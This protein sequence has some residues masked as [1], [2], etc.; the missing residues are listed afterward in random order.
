MKTS[1]SEQPAQTDAATMFL[2]RC[3]KTAIPA[4][5]IKTT[6]K[7]VNHK[8]KGATFAHLQ[9]FK[10]HPS[11]IEQD[12]Q[13]FGETHTAC[14]RKCHQ[15]LNKRVVSF[16]R[17][18]F[19]L[20]PSFKHQ[21]EWLQNE[22]IRRKIQG[23]HNH[24]Y[25][26]VIGEG[27]I[28][29]CREAFL[30]AFGITE[31]FYKRNCAAFNAPQ[32][33][34][35]KEV[36]RTASCD[37]ELCF[38]EWVKKEAQQIGDKLPHGDFLLSKANAEIRLPYPN[39]QV[40]YDRYR[41]FMVHGVGE[42]IGQIISYQDAVVL[43]KHHP[44]LQAI[45]L[46]KHKK[47]FSKCNT[48][49]RYGMK[50]KK[51]LTVLQKEHLDNDFY[52]HI[53]E[54]KKERAQYAKDKIKGIKESEN[55]NGKRLVVIMDAIDKWKTTFPFFINLPK[56]LGD[57]VY[58]FRTKMTACMAHG[59]GVFCF[60]ASEQVTQDTN[61]SITCLL[62]CLKHIQKQIFRKCKGTL[63]KMLC[64]QL[65]NASE[66]KS[67]HFLAFMAYLVEI[68]AFDVIKLSYLI[69]AHTHE[70]VDQWFSVWSRFLKYVLMQVL[71]IAAFVEGLMSAFKSEASKPKCVEQI[72]YC[73]DTSVLVEC[74]DKHL[75]RFDLDEKTNDKV[76]HFIFRR[77]SEG[78]SV[79]QYKM[80]RYSNAVYPR[81]YNVGDTHV[82]ETL[83]S[84]QVIGAKAEKN[85][86]TKEKYWVYTVKYKTNDV[87][88]HNEE[89]TLPAKECGIIM[90]PNIKPCELPLPSSFQLAP[91]HPEFQQ[92]LLDQ[93]KG[94]TSI[95]QV[96]QIEDT[97]QLE[98]QWWNDFFDS[99]PIDVHSF[100]DIQAFWIPPANTHDIHS[101][102]VHSETVLQI[103]DGCRDV[104]IVQHAQ[105]TSSK[106]RRAIQTFECEVVGQQSLDPLSKGTFVA[107][108]LNVENSRS[109]YPWEFVIAEVID[110]VDDLDTT[111]PHVEFKVQVY[112]PAGSTDNIT[113]DKKFTAWIGDNGRL[114][115][116]IVQ[117][118]SVGAIVELRPKTKIL[119][120]QSKALIHSLYF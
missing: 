18:L 93:R 41:Q 120:K 83:G 3:M 116:P 31:S 51:Q 65:D 107:V 44:E 24:F 119:T 13:R 106:R 109:W 108:Q 7:F 77:D 82:H 32:T 97:H 117:R 63:P 68:G 38:I 48:C 4:Q 104:E 46:I 10:M 103:D 88:S 54:T 84:G 67:K 21:R 90:F 49:L 70:D 79:M 87:L 76:H 85:A 99:I 50:I 37:V 114:F 34:S 56:S 36:Q 86:L 39:K 59:H 105:F 26:E 55:P 102:R 94:V 64:L 30:L 29:V 23:K 57:S 25:I 62:R 15:Y 1:A 28:R 22:L 9:T 100:Q 74:L 16:C 2:H 110:D 98:L 17:S 118:S 6:R 52:S 95:F 5:S 43:F 111:L 80:K 73:Y 42:D 89:L 40:L 20:L 112:R 33:P 115:Q 113:L 66:N 47:G 72:K 78:K 58:L 61:L 92:T 53:T 11:H 96:L 75:A 14:S 8:Q 45:K 91:A 12:L 60:W 101:K 27:P 19:V 35:S 69:V 81:R 71:T